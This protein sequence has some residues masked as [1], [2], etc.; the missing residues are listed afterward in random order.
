MKYSQIVINNK[1]YRQV[2]EDHS[3]EYIFDYLGEEIP[4]IT[5]QILNSVYGANVIKFASTD[6]PGTSLLNYCLMPTGTTYTGIK[7]YEPDSTLY[8]VNGSPTIN[9]N[10][11]TGFSNDDYISIT[12]G[13]AARYYYFLYIKTDSDV[14]NTQTLVYNDDNTLPILYI[15]DSHFKIK[16]K[17]GSISTSTLTLLPDTKYMFAIKYETY[18]GQ[19]LYDYSIKVKAI[20][21]NDP[22]NWVNSESTF[23][24]EISTS[25]INIDPPTGYIIGTDKAGNNF[26]GEFYLDYLFASTGW[27]KENILWR[28][29]EGLVTTDS[30]AGCLYPNYDDGTTRTY[31]T[32]N[33]S[34]KV[35]LTE[36]DVYQSLV[37]RGILT[38]NSH[39]P[40]TRVYG[41]TWL[42]GQQRDVLIRVYS[43]SGTELTDAHINS[44]KLCNN[45]KAVLTT[46]GFYSNNNLGINQNTKYLKFE[47][48]DGAYGELYDLPDTYYNVSNLDVLSINL[49][50]KVSNSIHVNI[51]D[52]ASIPDAQLDANDLHENFVVRCTG[53]VVRT[54]TGTSPV[55][56]EIPENTTTLVFSSSQ[57]S[58]FRQTRFYVN[59]LINNRV[60]LVKIS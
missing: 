35:V 44:V 22:Y 42:E 15:E 38:I 2:V 24:S 7:Y 26:K 4:V 51:V 31:N 46:V 3:I 28:A 20:D 21:T 60:K 33:N 52:D 58:T 49:V 57:G 53:G 37:R 14:T 8:S 18:T 40:W 41:A 39:T 30:F 50:T 55:N 19:N 6:V 36:D 29:V 16:N 47:D 34:Q 9:D 1:S 25:N 12:T 13:N 59:Q 27:K 45:N 23:S 48:L 43:P 32:F 10:V 17:N 11:I 54:I 56:I 5:T